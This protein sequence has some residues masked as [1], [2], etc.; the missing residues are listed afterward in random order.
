MP[1][2]E[3]VRR[4]SVGVDEGLVGGD[5]GEYRV[6]VL[7]GGGSVVVTSCPGVYVSAAE[8]LEDVGPRLGQHGLPVVEQCVGS[9]TGW[10]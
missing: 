4:G 5:G 3:G 6:G 10:V 7:E 9:E 8:V 2:G 1:G